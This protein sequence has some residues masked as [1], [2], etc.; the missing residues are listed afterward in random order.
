MMEEDI[1]ALLSSTRMP[2]ASAK[3]KRMLTAQVTKG[4]PLPKIRAEKAV[5]PRPWTMSSVK[6]V[7]DTV[8]RYVPA[9]LHSRPDQRMA[10][11]W[12]RL[13]LTPLVATDSGSSPMAQAE[14]PKGV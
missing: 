13:G 6:P 1:P 14:M 2:R 11:S 12:M 9:T 4:L 5:K 10:R 7:T 8:E 3:P